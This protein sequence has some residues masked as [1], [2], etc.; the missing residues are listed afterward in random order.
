MDKPIYYCVICQR[1]IVGE[2]HENVNVF[3][4]D[5]VPHPVGMTFDEDSKTQ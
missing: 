4:H 5:P 1:G 2:V 3:V